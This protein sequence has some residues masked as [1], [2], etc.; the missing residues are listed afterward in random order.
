MFFQSPVRVLAVSK[1][2]LWLFA[3]SSVVVSNTLQA[4]STPSEFAEL[5]LQELLDFSVEEKSQS[6]AEWS[7]AYSYQYGSFEGY[8]DGDSSLSFDE[9]L[10][11]PGEART[12]NNFPVLPTVITQ[13]V[14]TLSLN[15][16]YSKNLKLQVS[17]PL[18]EQ[19]TDHISVVPN[20]PEFV[21]YSHGVGDLSMRASWRLY[22]AK[23]G[24][25]LWL[26]S[27]LILPTGSIDEEGDTPRGPGDQQL[28]YTMQLGS[29]TYDIPLALEYHR[30]ATKLYAT[31]MIRTGKNSRNYRLGN[32]L[33]LGG[34]YSW[35]RYQSVRPVVGL[36][37]KHTGR[38]RG[39]DSS[40]T[41]PNPEFPYPAS[42]TNPNLYGG[43]VVAARA[44]LRFLQ[45]P[46][47]L[48]EMSEMELQFSLPVYQRLNGPQPKMRWSA[49]FTYSVGF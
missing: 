43:E 5:S 44:R 49:G 25:S 7:F 21:I 1:P 18:I 11:S 27:G 13:Q 6:P 34:E 14:H 32:S 31:A 36:S 35:T 20:Y 47:T 22:G 46:K 8:L 48:G 2:L 9:V 38:I 26:T 16:R 37:Y 29:G 45:L 40:L 30:A 3:A 33:S 28:P 4:Q 12:A 17:L 19:G 42:I 41:V 39:G 15:C 24:E 10:F 23:K